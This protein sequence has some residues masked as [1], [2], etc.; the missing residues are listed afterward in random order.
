MEEIAQAMFKFEKEA[1]AKP[2]RKMLSHA[3]GV[4]APNVLVHLQLHAHRKFVREHPGYELL[5]CK[6]SEH[7]TRE[8]LRRALRELALG[9]DCAHPFV[10]LAA[11]EH[12]LDFVAF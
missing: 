10:V 6:L 7:A 12:E 8:Q 3:L 11:C 9:D 1:W 4:R 5:R 2:P